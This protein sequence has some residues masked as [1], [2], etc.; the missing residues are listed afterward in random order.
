M[1]S[2]ASLIHRFGGGRVARLAAEQVRE[3]GAAGTLA[4]PARVP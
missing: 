1:D 3:H 2:L 4:R